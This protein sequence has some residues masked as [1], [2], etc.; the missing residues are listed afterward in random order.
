MEFTKYNKIIT[1]L[2]VL[3]ILAFVGYAYFATN[4]TNPEYRSNI[5]L[6]TNQ[7]IITVSIVL[8]ILT[9]F[10]LIL[11]GSTNRLTNLIVS[12]IFGI[13]FLAVFIDAATVNFIGIYNLMMGIDIIIMIIIIVFA[14]RMPKSQV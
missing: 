14:Y 3:G 2:W 1:V 8:I 13:G 4:E 12:S 6:I 9:I 7:E 11:K 10:S 5:S